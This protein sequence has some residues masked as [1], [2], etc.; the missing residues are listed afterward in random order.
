MASGS[1]PVDVRADRAVQG[2]VTV[3]TLGAFVFREPFVI[4]VLAACLGAGSSAR[5]TGAL[6]GAAWGGKRGRNINSMNGTT[7]APQRITTGG[8]LTP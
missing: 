7:V 1:V 4:P 3:I 2:A 5:T 8:R 6:M